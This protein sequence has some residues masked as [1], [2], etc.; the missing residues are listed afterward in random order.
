MPGPLGAF[1]REDSQSARFSS[2]PFSTDDGVLA[3]YFA[4]LLS[5]EA[6]PIPPEA[7]GSKQPPP[8]LEILVGTQDRPDVAAL[9]L[10]APALILERLVALT[11]ATPAIAATASHGNRIA[12]SGMTTFAGTAM[13]GAPVRA[14]ASRTPRAAAIVRASVVQR[15]G[16]CP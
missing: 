3:V 11:G 16:C 15:E 10:V 1:S 14:P 8:A 12:T 2:A 6:P 7:G 9:S 13:L 4:F 5:W